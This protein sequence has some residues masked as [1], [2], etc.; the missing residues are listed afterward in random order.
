MENELIRVCALAL[1]CSIGALILKGINSQSVS[2]LRICGVIAVFGTAVAAAGTI[3]SQTAELVDVS[4]VGEY[5]VR[6]LKALGLAML[7]GIGADICR[8]CGE[9]TVATGVETVGNLAI[10]S[11]CI[12][13]F[14][15]LIGYAHTLLEM[16]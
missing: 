12:P 8:D 1:V 15:E 10:L 4:T 6:M 14:S 16:G 5:A 3:F 9:N 7:S 13:L 2:A 11:L